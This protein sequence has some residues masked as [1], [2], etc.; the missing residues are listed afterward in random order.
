MDV[1]HSRCERTYYDQLV[2]E[3]RRRNLSVHDPRKGIRPDRARRADEIDPHLRVGGRRDRVARRDFGRDDAKTLQLVELVRRA[4]NDAIG[5]F[6]DLR[7]T[8]TCSDFSEYLVAPEYPSVAVGGD[9]GRSENDLACRSYRVHQGVVVGHIGLLRELQVDRDRAG[10]TFRNPIDYN[11]FVA[12][13]KREPR[14]TMR[15]A[16]VDERLVVN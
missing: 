5:I 4:T 3:R 11:R 15:P 7:V 6:A 16:K 1:L 10:P 14:M 13:R 12:T 9:L 2:V 8:G